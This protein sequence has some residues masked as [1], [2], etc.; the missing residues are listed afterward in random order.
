MS[1]RPSGRG[2]SLR[3]WG[4]GRLRMMPGPSALML[5][6]LALSRASFAPTGFVVN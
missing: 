4:I 5:A 6:G 1:W 3:G 2:R